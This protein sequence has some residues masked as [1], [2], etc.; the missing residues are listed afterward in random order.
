MKKSLAWIKRNAAKNC[1]RGL[2]E[3]GSEVLRKIRDGKIK[4]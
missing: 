4:A 3:T 1:D 2:K